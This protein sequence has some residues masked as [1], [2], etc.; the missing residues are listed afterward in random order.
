MK[1][2]SGHHETSFSRAHLRKNQSID[3]KTDGKKKYKKTG[4]VGNREKDKK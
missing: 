3:M 4:R 1:L 2:A